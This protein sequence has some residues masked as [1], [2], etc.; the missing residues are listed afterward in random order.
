MINL[1][2]FF[3]MKLLFLSFFTIFLGTNYTIG[4]FFKKARKEMTIQKSNGPDSN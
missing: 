2:N 1:Y 4:N 3:L